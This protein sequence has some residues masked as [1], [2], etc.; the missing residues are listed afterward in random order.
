MPKSD[1]NAKHRSRS[2][3]TA[4][5]I[6]AGMSILAHTNWDNRESAAAQINS[7]VDIKPYNP[8]KGNKR[9]KKIPMYEG[10]L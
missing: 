10:E 5:S 6:G 8:E 1:T 4:R 2:A 3:G 9:K 7:M